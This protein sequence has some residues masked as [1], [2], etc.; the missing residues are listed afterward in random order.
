MLL[1]QQSA[2]HDYDASLTFAD[3][4]FA[5]SDCVHTQLWTGLFGDGS[6]PLYAPSQVLDPCYV[7]C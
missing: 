6:L 7:A 2:I 5:S 1:H 4:R 3:L